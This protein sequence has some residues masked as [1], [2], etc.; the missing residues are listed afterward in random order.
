MHP[1]EIWNAPQYGLG[2]LSS[3]FLGIKCGLKA[4]LQINGK[5]STNSQTLKRA[6][7]VFL[8]L[9][10]CN[11]SPCQS[12][13]FDNVASARESVYFDTTDASSLF[14]VFLFL[15]CSLL[16]QSFSLPECLLWHDRCT[17]TDPQFPRSLLHI[18]LT[19]RHKIF[20]YSPRNEL[21]VL[22]VKMRNCCGKGDWN[23]IC[24]CEAGDVF[25]VPWGLS[26]A[27]VLAASIQTKT[28]RGRRNTNLQKPTFKKSTLKTQGRH[29]KTSLQQ[30][31]PSKNQP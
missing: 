30:N 11:V 9:C 18:T 2:T 16:L 4:S 24:V 21:L 20:T 3:T 28:Q 5:S 6:P 19:P 27:L 14:P 1:T 13:Y 17:L 7:P 15:C 31:Q 8:F 22:I 25:I 12:V 26:G 29:T 10:C 23:R